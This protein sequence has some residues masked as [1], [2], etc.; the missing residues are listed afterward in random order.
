M[1]EVENNSE[2]SVDLFETFIRLTAVLIQYT[3]AHH[4]PSTSH[5]ITPLTA[6]RLTQ[7]SRPSYR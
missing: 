4:L 2:V 7:L 1:P 3:A 6:G 5:R